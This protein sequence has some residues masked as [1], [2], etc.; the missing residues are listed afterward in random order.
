MPPGVIRAANAHFPA[1]L[2]IE[3]GI[4]DAISRPPLRINPQPTEQVALHP[5]VQGH[6]ENVDGGI[7]IAEEL[8]MQSKRLRA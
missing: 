7:E 8:G 3:L 6:R 1:E 2:V 4:R 5:G